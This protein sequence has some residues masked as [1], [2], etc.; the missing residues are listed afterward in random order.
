MSKY[1]KYLHHLSIET[2]KYIPKNSAHTKTKS[3]QYKN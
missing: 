3:D 1:V 2:Q